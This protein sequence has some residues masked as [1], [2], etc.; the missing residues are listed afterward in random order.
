MT[1]MTSHETMT[2]AARRGQEAFTG[3]L[4]IWADS[5]QRFAPTSDKLRGAVEVV[6]KM[7]DFA[8]HM[9]ASQR[10]FAKSLLA[11]TTSAAT[12]AASAAQDA[13]KD[14]EDVAKEAAPEK[15]GINS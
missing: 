5:V 11:V 15:S 12:K 3:A 2:D 7:Y 9:L 1:M 8:D 6:D 4:Q 14:M 13:A 10:E